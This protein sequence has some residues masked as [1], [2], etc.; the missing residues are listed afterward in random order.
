MMPVMDGEAFLAEL[1][2]H[3]AYQ[4]LPVVVVSAKEMSLSEMRTLDRKAL[5]ILRKDGALGECLQ[6]LVTQELGAGS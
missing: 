5:T 4:D 3:P 6:G 1:G 2:R